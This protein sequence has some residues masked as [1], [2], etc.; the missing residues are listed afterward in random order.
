M[1]RLIDLKKQEELKPC[2]FCGSKKIG[3]HAFNIDT[4]CYIECEKCGASISKEVR[5]NKNVEKMT[6]EEH[7]KKCWNILRRAWNKRVNG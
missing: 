7:D 1:W 4:T 5:F 3:M 6:V 2:T